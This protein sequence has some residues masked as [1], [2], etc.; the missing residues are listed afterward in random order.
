MAWRTNNKLEIVPDM[1]NLCCG[2]ARRACRFIKRGLRARYEC[3]LQSRQATKVGSCLSLCVKI[4]GN[5]QQLGRQKMARDQ[6]IAQSP[7]PSRM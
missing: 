7:S 1:S 6:N 3:E 4:H 5:T 2:Q